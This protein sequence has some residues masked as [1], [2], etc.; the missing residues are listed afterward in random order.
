MSDTASHYSRSHLN[1]EFAKKIRKRIPEEIGWYMV[2]LFYTALHLVDAY[3]V[4]KAWKP[5]MENHGER[6][7]EL[8]KCSELS[9]PF[10]GAYRSLQDMSEQVRYEPGFQAVDKHL[11][12]AEDSLRTVRL[13]LE[14]KIKRQLYKMV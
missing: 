2:V 4:T 14:S 6:N 10:R 8:K 3:L 5:S 13:F 12:Q 11:K 7:R 9:M 1:Q